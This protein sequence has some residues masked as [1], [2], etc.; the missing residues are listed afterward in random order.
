MHEGHLCA[1]CDKCCACLNRHNYVTLSH[2]VP[3]F[4]NFLEEVGKTGVDPLRIPYNIVWDGGTN[5]WNSLDNL[6]KH[7][8][9]KEEWTLNG[10]SKSVC[11]FKELTQSPLKS[12]IRLGGHVINNYFVASIMNGYFVKTHI[13]VYWT[14]ARKVSQTLVIDIYPTKSGM[15][16]IESYLDVHTIGREN[17]RHVGTTHPKYSQFDI[18]LH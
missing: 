15:T 14:H 10:P 17:H 13:Q 8:A 2:H 9:K 1:F 7:E 4:F 16:M 12:Y 6:E 18:F 3:S 11:M 5:K